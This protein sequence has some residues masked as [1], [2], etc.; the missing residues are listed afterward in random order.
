MLDKDTF[1]RDR[2][3]ADSRIDSELVLNLQ[4]FEDGIG[5]VTRWAVKG[6]DGDS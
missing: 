2:S 5:G 3:T 4:V 6:H 1:Q